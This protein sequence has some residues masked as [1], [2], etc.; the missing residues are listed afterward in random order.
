MS[1]AGGRGAQ[2]G[3]GRATYL[4]VGPG[5]GDVVRFIGVGHLAERDDSLD[6]DG[7]G[8]K[9]GGDGQKRGGGA[10]M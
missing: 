4:G 1:R 7:A 5:G 8:W 10:F 2:R 6:G 3:G 9:R